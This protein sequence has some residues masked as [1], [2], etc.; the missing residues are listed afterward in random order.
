[1]QRITLLLAVAALA[2]CSGP[3]LPPPNTAQAIF[4]RSAGA[5]E[6]TVSSVAALVGAALVSPSGVRYQATGL[7]LLSSP[8]VAY[9]PPPSIASA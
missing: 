7:S 5:V 9:N 8:Y 6:V 1:M 2:G 4:D 3:K